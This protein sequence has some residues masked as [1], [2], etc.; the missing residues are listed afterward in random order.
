MRD[1]A[2][3]LLVEQPGPL[4]GDGWSVQVG[5]DGVV[6]HLNGDWTADDSGQARAFSA[7]KI[8]AA[9]AGQGISFD[10]GQLGHWDSSL[11]VFISALREAARERGIPFDDNALPRPASRLL[12]LIA[13]AAPS[14]RYAPPRSTLVDHVGQTTIDGWNETVAVTALIGDTVLSGGTA[15][16]GRLRMRGSDL[17]SC[18][19]EAGVAALPIVT[20]V[21]MLVGGIVAFVG[22]VQLRR[23]GADIFIADL[24]GVAMIREMSSL[25][26]AIVMSGRTGGAYAAHIATML[27]NEE[28]DA[29]RAIGIPV[30]DYLVLPRMIA[31]T[32]TMPLLYIYGCA[33]GIFGGFVVAVAMLNLSPDSFIDETRASVAGN[34][35]VFGLVKSI[36]F[37]VL[38]AIVG[39]RSGLRAGRSAADVGRAATTAVVLGIVGVIALDALF[40]VCANALD[41]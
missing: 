31:L 35:I 15:I 18:V 37:G 16:R 36:A 22:S 29:L 14:A 10:T 30:Y 19:H 34:Q 7:R 1:R 41:F 38:I 32:F 40:A 3:P 8:A 24:V 12:A 4:T 21:N 27:G 25:M 2:S 6:V 11:L 33:V 17:L 39:C 20:I 23:F 9:S 28:I 13:D 26:T 5:R